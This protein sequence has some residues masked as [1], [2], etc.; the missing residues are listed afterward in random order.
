[1]NRFEPKFTAGNEAQLRYLSGD[2]QVKVPGD[3]VRC[4]VTGK[5]IPLEL[6]R[7]WDAERQ[8]AYASAEV[9]FERQWPE[10]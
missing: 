7:Y 10:E 3:F 2:Y 8:E 1:M 9:A 6:L 4:A 5:P